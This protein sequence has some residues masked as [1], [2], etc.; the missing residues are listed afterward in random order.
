MERRRF[1]REV[2]RELGRLEG[3]EKEEELVGSPV[4]DASALPLPPVASAV[5]QEE[6][7]VVGYFVPEL[8]EEKKE[9]EVDVKEEDKKGK[10]KA[11]TVEEV[12]DE[13]ASSFELV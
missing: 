10:G 1:V 9:V 12:Q 11:V 2:E 13:D 3:G 5:D 7:A 4:V 6:E 8:I